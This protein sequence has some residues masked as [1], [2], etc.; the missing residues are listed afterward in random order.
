MLLIL[1][2]LMLRLFW[3]Y[4]QKT[5]KNIFLIHLNDPNKYKKIKYYAELITLETIKLPVTIGKR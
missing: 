1:R 5:W 2:L 3:V 4:H